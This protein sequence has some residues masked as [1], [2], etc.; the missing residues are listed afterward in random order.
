VA[1]LYRTAD[2]LAYPS[3]HEGSA[4]AILEAMASGLPIVTTPNSGSLVRDGIDGFITPLRD[5]DALAARIEQLYRNPEE[6][7]HMGRAAC[8]HAQDFSWDHYRLRLKGLLDGM[9]AQR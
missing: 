2:I 4:L 8:A 5:I 9:L 7:R 6:R 1:E 3:L